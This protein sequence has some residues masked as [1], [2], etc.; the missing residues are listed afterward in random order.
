MSFS[1]SSSCLTI[2]A[3][4]GRKQGNML[5][6]PL[7]EGCGNIIQLSRDFSYFL[8]GMRSQFIRLLEGS[9]LVCIDSGH[10]INSFGGNLELLKVSH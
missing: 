3:A 8:Q 2:F 10:T 9:G 5:L 6:L 4:L 1:F 7:F